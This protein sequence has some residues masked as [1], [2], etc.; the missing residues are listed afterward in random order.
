[1]NPRPL[2]I[3]TRDK[4]YE[5]LMNLASKS[6]EKY[7]NRNL[8]WPFP[9]YHKYSHI[10][11]LAVNYFIQTPN[12]YYNYGAVVVT[13]SSQLQLAVH[14]EANSECL[15]RYLSTHTESANYS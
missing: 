11:Y 15:P 8:T 14:N 13:S 1:M 2:R 9:H 4:A 6:T 5:R 3:M 12:P 7:P 10:H